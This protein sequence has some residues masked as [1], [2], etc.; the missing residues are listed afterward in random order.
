MNRRP[1]YKDEIDWRDLIKKPEKL[2]GYSYI[3][4]LA[5]FVGIGLLYIRNLNTIGR[6]AVRP[7]ILQDSTGLIKDIPLQSP[8]LIP[9]VDIMKA[10]ISSPELVT[11]GRELYKANCTTCHG[12][13]GLGDGPSASM[14]NPKPRNLHSLE[15]WKNGSKVTQ[16][17][18]TLEE[19][20]PG[21]G[22]ASYNYMPPE[23]RFAVIHY[24]R[25]LAANQPNDSLIALKQLDAAYQLAK[26]MD[27]PGQIPVKKAMRLIEKENVADDVQVQ[28]AV[29]Q[30][31]ASHNY[32]AELLRRHAVDEKRVVTCVVQ[33]KNHMRS[34]DDFIKI[35]SADPL[36]SGFKAS[37]VRL[38]AIEWD[39]LYHYM[40]SVVP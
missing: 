32:G 22:M 25:T 40:Y 4:I 19:G 16:I 33:M 18:K 24:I 34:V 36:H 29:L 7:T 11:R 2:F 31:A 27:V 37:V 12:D 10:G 35:I 21:G 14:L 30:I 23:E 8:R 26:G 5:V 1:H 15:N 39:E 20:I 38:S 3:Y 9:P 28:E 13:N 6:N 17:Y